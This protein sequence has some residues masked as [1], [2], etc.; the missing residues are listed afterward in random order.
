MSTNGGFL[1][2]KNKNWIYIYRINLQQSLAES[3]SSYR[4][5]SYANKSK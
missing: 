2:M 1:K 5:G 4:T 3:G